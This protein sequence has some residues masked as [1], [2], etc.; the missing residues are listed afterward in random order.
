[1][2]ISDAQG[3][4]PACV[5]LGLTAEEVWLHPIN[6]GTCVLGSSITRFDGSSPGAAVRR[7]AQNPEMLRL[8]YV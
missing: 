1:M 5:R 3:A 2:C 6:L 7:A 8:G 4:R